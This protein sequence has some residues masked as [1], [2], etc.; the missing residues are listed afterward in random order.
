MAKYKLQI[1]ETRVFRSTLVVET[2]MT[3]DELDSKLDEIERTVECDM[4][5]LIHALTGAEIKIIGADFDFD[6]KGELESLKI[7]E[8]EEV[9]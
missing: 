4:N 1:D 3:E 7:P 9:E 5:D 8:M 2:D 6:G